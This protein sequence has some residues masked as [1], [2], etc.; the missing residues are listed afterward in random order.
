[1]EKRQAWLRRV[2]PLSMGLLPTGSIS[3][4]GVF[5]SPSA[6]ASFMFVKFLFLKA[7]L[8]LLRSGNGNVCLAW[9]PGS[10]SQRTMSWVHFRVLWCLKQNCCVPKGLGALE[11]PWWLSRLPSIHRRFHASNTSAYLKRKSPNRK[12]LKSSWDVGRVTGLQEWQLV[13][14]REQNPLL[15]ASG[16]IKALF[17]QKV[18]TNRKLA[19]SR[20]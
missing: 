17:C 18:N 3:T 9:F 7:E 5:V 15:L 1:M 12:T 8:F 16:Q 20:K 13:T 14:Q 19:W 6:K 4:S 2:T 10:F 11:G